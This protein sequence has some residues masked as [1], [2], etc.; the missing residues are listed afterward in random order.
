MKL[1]VFWSSIVHVFCFYTQVA[2]IASSL[3]SQP[4]P[5]GSCPV[6]CAPTWHRG[7]GATVTAPASSSTPLLRETWW[8]W[9]RP[10]GLRPTSAGPR[11]RVSASCWPTTAWGQSP[12]RKAPLWL[13]THAHRTLSKRRPSSCP[14]NPV[15]SRSTWRRTGTN[16]LWCAPCWPSRWWCSPCSSSTGTEIIWSPCWSRA[17]VPTCS[18]RSRG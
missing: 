3:Q 4:T 8:L 9:L 11:R 13:V 2:P 5:S 18:R 6:S 10:T 12:A 15:L 16:W 17:S 7:G 1:K 14:A